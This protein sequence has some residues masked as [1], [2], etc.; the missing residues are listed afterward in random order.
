MVHSAQDGS[1]WDNQGHEQDMS[2]RGAGASDGGKLEEKGMH[3][4]QE[5]RGRSKVGGC[6]HAQQVNPGQ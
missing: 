6:A 5:G 4:C 1:K 2:G 3:S